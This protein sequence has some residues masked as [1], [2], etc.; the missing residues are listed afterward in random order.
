MDFSNCLALKYSNHLPPYE[1]FNNNI[2]MI[3]TANVILSHCL[4]VS[5][6]LITLDLEQFIW[7]CLPCSCIVLC[8]KRYCKCFLKVWDIW[9]CFGEIYGCQIYFRVQ[10]CFP[11]ALIDNNGKSTHSGYST[12]LQREI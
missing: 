4:N 9:F 3:L 10:I 7:T 11:M 6:A 8:F 12:C 5:E 1:R 2:V